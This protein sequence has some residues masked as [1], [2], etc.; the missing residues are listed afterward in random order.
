[1][2]SLASAEGME[3][4]WTGKEKGSFRGSGVA[5]R[6]DAVEDLGKHGK[7]GGSLSR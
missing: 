4:A 2:Q 7:H 6:F 5:H 1:M 3:E